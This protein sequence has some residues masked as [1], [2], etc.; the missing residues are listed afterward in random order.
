MAAANVI[1]CGVKKYK[2]TMAFFMLIVRGE[3]GF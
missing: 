1:A 2:Q 3:K